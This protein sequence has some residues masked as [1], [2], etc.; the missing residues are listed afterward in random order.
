[1]QLI[2]STPASTRAPARF[3]FAHGGKDG[4]PY[5]VERETYDRTIDVVNAALRRSHID[6]QRARIAAL[7]R[8]AKLERAA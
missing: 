1:M 2:Y 3:A 8:L 4:T 6:R 7:R 5:P